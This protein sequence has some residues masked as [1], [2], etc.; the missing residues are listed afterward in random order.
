MRLDQVNQLAK[1]LICTTLKTYQAIEPNFPALYHTHTELQ[2]I[3]RITKCLAF[4]LLL[5]TQF[6]NTTEAQ[7]TLADKQYVDANGFFEIVPPKGWRIQK[8]P[9]DPRGKVAFSGPDDAEFR[10]LAKTLEIDGFDAM[11]QELKDIEKQ[12][13]T[14]TNIETISFAGTRA[15][16][17]S[18]VFKGTRIHFIDFM[19]GNTSHNLMYSATRPVFDR[20]FPI[21]QTSMRTYQPVLRDMQ[22]G[23]EERHRVARSLRLAQLFLEQENYG[24]SGQHIDEGL[25]IDPDNADILEIQN[26]LIASLESRAELPETPE[27]TEV[28]GETGGGGPTNPLL[29]MGLSVIGALMLMNIKSLAAGTAAP[30]IASITVPVMGLAA[31][32]GGLVFMEEDGHYVLLVITVVLLLLVFTAPLTIP[33]LIEKYRK[34]EVVDTKANPNS[35]D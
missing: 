30:G 13:G 1:L 15:V 11:L 34:P 27:V 33:L 24:L 14:D 29:F 9:D 18:F 26:A 19:I 10:I 16:Q 31:L 21:V 32:V 28:G 8:Y 22:P 2:L 17:R 5:L 25:A 6:A 20:S 12:I 35:E 7:D 3:G 4:T 23:E